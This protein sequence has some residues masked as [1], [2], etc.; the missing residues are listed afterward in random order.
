[1]H[2]FFK[3]HIW[4][5]RLLARC[6]SFFVFYCRDCKMLSLWKKKCGSWRRDS[7]TAPA[8][9]HLSSLRQ[10]QRR[11]TARLPVHLPASRSP[12]RSLYTC[13]KCQKNVCKKCIGRE[14]YI[15]LCFYCHENPEHTVNANNLGKSKTSSHLTQLNVVKP[16]IGLKLDQPYSL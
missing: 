9:S 2:V 8:P 16:G 11:R 14:A 4:S 3:P 15:I 12:L 1:M 7:H 5:R 6:S 13:S 10:A